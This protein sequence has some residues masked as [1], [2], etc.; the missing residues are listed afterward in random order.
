M[1]GG[2]RSTYSPLNRKKQQQLVT[3]LIEATEQTMQHLPG[4]AQFEPILC[5]VSDAIGLG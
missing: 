3:L 1:G 2:E 5:E 4:F